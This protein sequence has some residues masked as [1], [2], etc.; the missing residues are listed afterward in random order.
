MFGTFRYVLALVVLVNHFSTVPMVG[1]YAVYVF[2]MLSGYLMAHILNTSYKENT[3]GYVINRIIRIYP[4]YFVIL[5]LTALSFVLIPGF[6]VKGKTPDSQ[7]I[8]YLLIL[9]A[10]L[11]PTAWTLKIELFYYVLM[12]F[13]ARSFDRVRIWFHLSIGIAVMIAAL[14]I[15]GSL[16]K[17]TFG[18]VVAAS[19][20]FSFGSYIW[21]TRKD[22]PA[23]AYRIMFA[24]VLLSGSLAFP[25]LAPEIQY[26]VAEWLS[27]LATTCFG[28]VLVLE[29]S[30]IKVEG[31]G[32][33]ID[34]FLGDLSYPIYLSH[35]LI[36]SLVGLALSGVVLTHLFS[37]G[38]RW[39]VEQPLENIRRKIRDQR[40]R[41]IAKPLRV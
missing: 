33:R 19:V 15:E 16:I 31:W 13:I 36:G 30:R 18:N 21:H 39:Y 22:V 41:L 23:S 1:K 14:T 6:T 5:G 32:K 26:T 20:P 38:I 11:V 3:Q 17:P 24:A 27:L 12:I 35:M 37:L 40:P 25:V 34:G 2:F 7:W 9:D 28:G 4:T 8:N 10:D 29:L